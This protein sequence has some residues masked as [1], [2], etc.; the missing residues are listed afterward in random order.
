MALARGACASG[1]Q[2]TRSF[3]L[4]DNIFNRRLHT[5]PHKGAQTISSSS[6][7]SPLYFLSMNEWLKR[8]EM[9]GCEKETSASSVSMHTG[10][11]C[12]SSCMRMTR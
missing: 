6:C 2:W 1:R 11:V 10:S 9:S 4:H 5:A 12:A 8:T 7:S 3:N